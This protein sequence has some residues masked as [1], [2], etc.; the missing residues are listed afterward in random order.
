MGA[1]GSLGFFSFF[2]FFSLG[3]FPVKLPL[4]RSEEEVWCE[5]DVSSMAAVEAAAAA[6]AAWMAAFV[7]LPDFVKPELGFVDPAVPVTEVVGAFCVV[8][9][10]S[11]EGESLA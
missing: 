9:D 5:A 7:G 10:E 8:V 11:V 1:L 3:A 2:S 6:M 4:T